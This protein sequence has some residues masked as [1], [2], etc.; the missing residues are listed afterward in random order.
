MGVPF[1]CVQL[2]GSRTGW[3][4]KYRCLFHA[5]GYQ[6]A[7]T[8]ENP[9]DNLLSVSALGGGQELDGGGGVVIGRS[10]QKPWGRPGHSP[11]PLAHPTDMLSEEADTS[12][13]AR[14][15]VGGFGALRAAAFV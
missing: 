1:S 11:S 9:W 14:V 5:A 8:T 15:W 13:A 6:P 3:C 12:R 4:V 10:V 7:Y 2:V